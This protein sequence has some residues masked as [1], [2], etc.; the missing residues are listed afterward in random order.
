MTRDFKEYTELFCASTRLQSVAIGLRE[1]IEGQE[2]AE[3]GN[4]EWGANMLGQMD[5]NSKHF[6]KRENPE[7]CV[8]ATELRPKFY[9][10]ILKLGI[11]FNKSFSERIY[12]TLRSCGKRVQLRTEELKQAYQMFQ[13]MADD[14]LAEL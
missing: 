8:I 9:E 2:N 5:W 11:P 14:T 6:L 13:S 12:E 10:T 3:R 4:F 7:L 1:I